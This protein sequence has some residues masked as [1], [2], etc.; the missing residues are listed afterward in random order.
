[1]GA[2][3]QFDRDPAVLLAGAGGHRAGA[4]PGQ[5]VAD[6]DDGRATVGRHTGPGGRV[7]RDRERAR[8]RAGREPGPFVVEPKVDGLA[9]SLLYVDGVLVR[10][11][12]WGDGTTT[13][14]IKRAGEVIPAVVAPVLEKRPPEEPMTNRGWSHGPV[15]SA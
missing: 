13:V 8:D 3:R 10:G 4:I 2:G 15:R 9:I 14:F 1:V 11:A 6:V 7:R 5:L 12:T